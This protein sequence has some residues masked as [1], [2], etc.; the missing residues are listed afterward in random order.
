MR[1]VIA[2][3]DLMAA[4]EVNS[5]LFFAKKILGEDVEMKSE[6][7]VV[8]I[9][10]EN[11]KKQLIIDCDGVEKDGVNISYFD[12]NKMMYN[13]K[14]VYQGDLIFALK[15]INRALKAS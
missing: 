9:V 11:E 6:G 13:E 8:K 1:R 12:G 3:A 4:I 10:T 5:G 7:K 14:H 15:R 2:K